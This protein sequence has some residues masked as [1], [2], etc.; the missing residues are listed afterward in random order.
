MKQEIQGSV[1]GFTMRKFK[2]SDTPL[3]PME[4]Q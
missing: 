1:T 3:L 4:P 2:P